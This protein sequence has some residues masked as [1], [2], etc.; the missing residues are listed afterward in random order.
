M[1]LAVLLVLLGSLPVVVRGVRRRI[2]RFLAARSRIRL[3]V[4]PAPD[5][6]ASSPQRSSGLSWKEAGSASTFP[7]AVL[8][9][10]LAQAR[11]RAGWPPLCR[12]PFVIREGILDPGDPDPDHRTWM[13]AV[14]DEVL[15]PLREVGRDAAGGPIRVELHVAGPAD[16]VESLEDRL[17]EG[18]R[19]AR[20]QSV[21]PVES[22][23]DLPDDFRVVR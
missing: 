1:G 16:D 10:H 8:T 9:L 6:A 2:R 7:G 5:V 13:R 3:R 15:D 19:A 4:E 18:P 21:E 14:P 22:D 23:R 20:V 11:L 17:D 12:E